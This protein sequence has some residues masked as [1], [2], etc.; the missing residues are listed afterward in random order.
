MPSS[1]LIGFGTWRLEGTIFVR[2][3]YLFIT[4]I[5]LKVQWWKR[6]HI[7]KIHLSTLNVH[8]ACRKAILY[9]TV[10]ILALY[11][12]GWPFIRGLSSNNGVLSNGCAIQ[13]INAFSYYRSRSIGAHYFH[14]VVHL[15]VINIDQWTHKQN[16]KE[17]RRNKSTR[18]GGSYD[19]LQLVV[20][21]DH[22]TSRQSLWD[23]I[24]RPIKMQSQQYKF[25]NFARAPTAICE[26]M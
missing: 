1:N 13:Y 4:K 24:M 20:V 9:F 8:S 11:G 5:I 26:H 21:E 23:L 16:R 25:N 19:V 14:R 3:I 7:N 17:V 22:Q 6:K 15:V 2:V 10:F 12:S 18:K